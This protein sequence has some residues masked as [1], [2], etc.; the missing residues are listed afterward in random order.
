MRTIRADVVSAAAYELAEGPFWDAERERL[1]W[2]DIAGGTVLAGRLRADSVE[3][4]AEHRFPST[5]AAVVPTADDGL[6]VALRDGLAS[7]TAGGVARTGRRVLPDGDNSRFN[8]GACD[9]SGRFLVG[10]MSL[11]DREGGERLYRLDRHGTLEVVDDG[12]TLSNGLGWSPDGH[13]MYSVDS[14]P[15]IVWSRSYEPE[16]GDMGARHQHL[17][18]DDGTP[19]GLC[20]DAD[21]NLWVA[22][23][24]TG[25]IRCFT[26]GGEH[27][28]T[29]DV[30]APHT[31]SVAF[32][33]PGRDRLLITTA[34][35]DLSAAQLEEHPFSGHLFL[36]DVGTEGVPAAAWGGRCADVP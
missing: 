20:V 31:S 14:V 3:V 21:G 29:V 6:L 28:A 4:I 15:G 2:V 27:V 7:I 18:I 8:D 5:V 10:S 34:R 17:R 24:G 36:A 30:A 12:L 22:V 16:S 9:P 25:Q 33:G 11:D 26:P 13:T 35:E 19:D 1:L 32:V 23:W